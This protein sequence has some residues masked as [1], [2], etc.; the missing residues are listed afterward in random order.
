VKQLEDGYVRFVTLGF[1]FLCAK[2]C[3]FWCRH[4]KVTAND[5]VGRFWD[6]VYNKF[7]RYKHH[8][9]LLNS[10]F[11]RLTEINTA[12]VTHTN[13]SQ[14]QA[15][16]LHKQLRPARIWNGCMLP[17]PLC[18]TLVT[19]C[20][21]QITSMPKPC[22]FTQMSPC[23]ICHPWIQWH[24]INHNITGNTRLSTKSNSS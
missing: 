6:T 11:N 18:F 4:V 20:L 22:I 16:E 3:L 7:Q 13:A 19:H 5:K 23:Q 24:S 1:F 9:Q 15:N 2:F 17:P 21:C 12:V 10:I 14:A 8:Q